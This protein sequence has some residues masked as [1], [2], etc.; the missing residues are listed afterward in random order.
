MSCVCCLLHASVQW[1]MVTARTSFALVSPQGGGETTR[2][3]ARA[4]LS[5]HFVL[6]SDI[7]SC[8]MSLTKMCFRM[9]SWER[10]H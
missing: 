1:C 7:F 10:C 2:A 9:T 3:Y 6:R 5:S 8:R 4:Y